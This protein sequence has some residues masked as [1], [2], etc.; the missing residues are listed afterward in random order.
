M[1]R[2]TLRVEVRL[3]DE[4]AK[5]REGKLTFLDNS[6][7]EGTGTVKLRATVDNKDRLFWPG[8]FARIRLILDTHHSAVLVPAD[9]PQLSAKGSFVYVVKQDDSA[10]LRP[11]TVGQR[12]GDLIVI[13]QGLKQGER[14]VTNGQLGV[15]PGGKVQIATP[16]PIKIQ[17]L[18]REI[19]DQ[20]MS[21]SELFIRRPVMTMVLTVSVHS[22]WSSQ[23]PATAGQRFA[24]GGLSGHSGASELSGRESRYGGEQYR[25]TSRTP[26]HADQRTG[27]GDL[28]EHSGTHQPDLAVCVGQKHRCGGYRCPDGDITGHRQFAGG[29]AFAADIL[30]NQS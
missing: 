7:Q 2:R 23:L 13:G 12:H 30:E 3:A 1:A 26:V 10:E 4:T 5:A 25:H 17:R 27:A 29:S 21:F 6:V 15:T 16:E 9:A 18:P 28:Q 11:V 8:R 14:V 22:L 20:I 24:G 19:R